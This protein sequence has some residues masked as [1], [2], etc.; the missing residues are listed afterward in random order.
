MHAD[1]QLQ[2]T[3][4]NF[5]SSQHCNCCYACELVSGGFRAA[6]LPGQAT[7]TAHAVNLWVEKNLVPPPIR[8]ALDWSVVLTVGEVCPIVPQDNKVVSNKHN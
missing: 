6:R 5:F 3:A 4:E 1:I 2:I 8:R 7:H